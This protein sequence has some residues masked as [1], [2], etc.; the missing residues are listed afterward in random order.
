MYL[1][2]IFVGRREKRLP[3]MVA[4]WVAPQERE[5]AGGRERTYTD[6]VS[7]HGVRVLSTHAWQAGEQAE[8]SP[9]KGEPPV[10]GKA[11]YCQK[12]DN[13]HYCVGFKIAREPVP[14]SVLERFNGS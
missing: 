4:V 14:W 11:V 8:I 5:N 1:D 3:I 13:E 9:V 6:N 10:R 12:L 2:N 7:G